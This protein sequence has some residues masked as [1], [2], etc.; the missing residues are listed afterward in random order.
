MKQHDSVD[1]NGRVWGPHLPC[2]NC[3]RCS[4]Y[5][6]CNGAENAPIWSLIP[7]KH[8]LNSYLRKSIPL[9]ILY[10]AN[11]SMVMRPITKHKWSQPGYTNMTVS[12]GCF[13]GLSS[14]QMPIQYL[15][16]LAEW[17]ICSMNVQLRILRQLRKAVASTW[18]WISKKPL[19][20]TS[21]NPC[22]EELKVHYLVLV[23]CSFHIHGVTY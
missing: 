21:W 18:A 9:S 7:V 20:F 14:H 10:V 3:S 8:C 5:W 22:P 12:P 4:C 13:S 19:R 6:S 1:R 16:N 2:V 17:G 11:S 15:W 23:W